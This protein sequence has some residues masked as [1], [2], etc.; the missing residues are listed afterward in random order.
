MFVWQTNTYAPKQGRIELHDDELLIVLEE[1]SKGVSH[2]DY[3]DGVLFEYV[4]R[5]FSFPI[6]VEICGTIKAKPKALSGTQNSK[7]VRKPYFERIFGG[8]RGA[9]WVVWLFG[10][11][12]RTSVRTPNNLTI[13]DM[14]FAEFLE[15]GF[16]Q[17]YQ[18]VI[19][20]EEMQKIAL[21]VKKL[22]PLSCMCSTGA[23]TPWQHGSIDVFLRRQHP[24]APIEH[25]IELG[26]C[27]ICNKSWSFEESGDSHYSY[28]YR[29]RPFPDE[30]V[31]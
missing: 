3:L 31:K 14:S 19:G 7:T 6:A 10:K 21:A 29:V 15:N 20:A 5:N 8:G 4:V 16:P 26:R 11:N 1:E 17:E 13:P 23:K 9:L 24:F 22:S 2:Q 18:T 27:T 30:Y 25:S 12:I 28:H